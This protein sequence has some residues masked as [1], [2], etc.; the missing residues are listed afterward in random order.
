MK[1]ETIDATLAE[2]AKVIRNQRNIANA[3][4]NLA[5][6]KDDASYWRGY[7]GG[8]AKAY[9]SIETMLQQHKD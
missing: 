4:V 7:E 3:E 9:R 2:I 8:L 5:K 6:C 1:R